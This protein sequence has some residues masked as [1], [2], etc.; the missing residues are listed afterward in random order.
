LVQDR[1][2]FQFTL[3][4]GGIK[5]GERSI[6]AAAREL[7]EETGL[8]TYAAGRLR[9]CDIGTPFAR[10]HVC[11]VKVRG[12]VHLNHKELSGYTWW[13]QHSKLRVAPSVRRILTT[14]KTHHRVPLIEPKD[15]PHHHE[16]KTTV[17]TIFANPKQYWWEVPAAV[18]IIGFIIRALLQT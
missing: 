6:D 15:I 12:E 17:V 18:G 5:R 16:A 14:Q 8:K 7:F 11:L 13:D 2:H 9:D 3:P 1:G 10:H 4:G